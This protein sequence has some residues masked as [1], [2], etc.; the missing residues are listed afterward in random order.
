M[1]TLNKT[2]LTWTVEGGNTSLSSAVTFGYGS[3][4]SAPPPQTTIGQAPACN[5]NAGN[6]IANTACIIFNSRG[7]PVDAAGAPT[8]IDAIYLTDEPRCNRQHLRHGN[9]S[10]GRRPRIDARVGAAV[11]TAIRSACGCSR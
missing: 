9:D 2:A 11:K 5:D 4:S 10:H 7:V 8:A 6:A 3:I 1:E